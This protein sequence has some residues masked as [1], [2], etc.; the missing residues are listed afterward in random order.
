M[1]TRREFLLNSTLA[2]GAIFVDESH[3][4]MDLKK[5][6]PINMANDLLIFATNWGFE[7]DVNRFCKAAKKSG[8][9]G[10]EVWVPNDMEGIKNLRNAVDQYGL[11]LGLLTGG[12]NPN[13]EIHSKQ[14]FEAIERAISMKP[15]YINC[16]SGKDF[17]PFEDNV[18]MLQH[19]IKRSSESG[20]PICHETHR[21]RS[22]FAAHITKNFMDKLEGLKLT[23]DISHW[24]NVHESLLADQELAVNAALSRT[25][26]IHARVGHEEGP[27]VND[28]R[29]PEWSTAFNTH[30]KW[31][32]TVV[33]RKRKE[34]KTIT[35]LTEFGPPNYMQTLPYSGMPVSNQW[36]INVYMMN[37]LRKRYS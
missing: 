23:L 27:Q 35:I 16:H 14:F 20:I 17:F 15:V 28:P 33:A 10:I 4:E 8:Y 3:V 19:T 13:P 25:E 22:L 29:A 31:W 34:G 12:S 11:K 1:A 37:M 30:L 26:H 21:G 18:K 2:T 24:C 6:Q 5:K 36:E 32:D 9:D 7:G